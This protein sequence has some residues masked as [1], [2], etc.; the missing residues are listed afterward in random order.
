M[1]PARLPLSDLHELPD[2][3]GVP[4][5][6]EHD[7]E[8][9]L[10]HRRRREELGVELGQLADLRGVALPHRLGRVPLDRRLLLAHSL[11]D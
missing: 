8:Q 10:H 2:L 5:E 3:R 9:R 11:N 1:S 6:V 4:L 7:L